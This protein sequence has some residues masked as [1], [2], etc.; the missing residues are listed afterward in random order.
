[1]SCRAQGEIIHE[2]SCF[3]NNATW[4][5]EQIFTVQ[6]GVPLVAGD[7]VSV[8]REPVYNTKKK[9]HPPG[10]DIDSV[11]PIRYI[12]KTVSGHYV[13]RED[14]QDKGHDDDVNENVSI[15]AS[16]ALL[17]ENAKSPSLFEAQENQ[18]H[19]RSAN[20]QQARPLRVGVNISTA[21]LSEPR[22]INTAR[23]EVMNTSRGRSNESVDDIMTWHNDMSR[24]YEMQEAHCHLPRT[25]THR[26][27]RP[28]SVRARTEKQ[29]DEGHSM[30]NICHDRLY[31]NLPRSSTQKDV[32]SYLPVSGTSDGVPT[33]DRNKQITNAPMISSDMYARLPIVINDISSIIQVSTDS[34][35]PSTHPEHSTSSNPR[36]SVLSPIL[37]GSSYHNEHLVSRWYADTDPK[38]FSSSGGMFPPVRQP[39]RHLISGYDNHSPG[40]S[41]QRRVRGINNPQAVLGTC[42][43]RPSTSLS[44]FQGGFQNRQL[45]QSSCRNTA[46]VADGSSVCAGYDTSSSGFASG[47]E[48]TMSSQSS[49]DVTYRNDLTMCRRS[50]QPISSQLSEELTNE[51]EIRNDL[52]KSAD[53]YREPTN[54]RLAVHM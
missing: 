26:D 20:H 4:R 5:Q 45:L 38:S 25:S 6:Q 48:L 43:I 39:G 13:V 1:M 31:Y 12:R 23:D 42:Q 3:V 27:M 15:S 10:C 33:R 44:L 14:L 47:R 32:H 8:Q 54:H 18:G 36:S 41:H 9:V 7:V 22:E 35:A 16:S 51:N 30:S 50:Q 53:P 29:I 17:L 19:P 28:N 2:G 11:R 49:Q 34:H 24:S 21:F 52:M 46:C 40:I 37:N